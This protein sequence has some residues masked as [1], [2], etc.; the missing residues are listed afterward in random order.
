MYV[1][2]YNCNCVIGIVVVIV[3]VT[4]G[5]VKQLSISVPTSS[6][7]L[8]VQIYRNMFEVNPNEIL[9]LFVYFAAQLKT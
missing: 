1:C 8:L 2:V 7:Q 3:N 6:V 9:S 5:K 4:L